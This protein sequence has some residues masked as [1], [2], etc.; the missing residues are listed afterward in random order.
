[1]Y[2]T[3]NIIPTIPLALCLTA[4]AILTVAPTLCNSALV[5][6]PHY[7]WHCEFQ[8]CCDSQ[9]SFDNVWQ[10]HYHCPYTPE[11]LHL[12]TVILGT[13][14]LDLLSPSLLTPLKI[15]HAFYYNTTA[16]P[17]LPFE[18]CSLIYPHQLNPSKR[19][20]PSWNLIFIF[21]I[22][23]STSLHTRMRSTIVVECKQSR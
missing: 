6:S 2:V 12:R 4:I 17:T 3:G 5:W 7:Q 13:I 8:H 20:N 9:N 10:L 11:M 16:N 18:L 14:L 22:I 15:L 23:N 21:W 1:V 19:C